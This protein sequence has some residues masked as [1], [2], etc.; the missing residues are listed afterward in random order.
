MNLM[1]IVTVILQI[2]TTIVVGIVGYFMKDK[3]ASLK[4]AD[5]ANEC[6]ITKIEDSF[7]EFKEK[8]PLLYTTRE[9]QIRS[10]AALESRVDKLGASMDSNFEK[11][12]T[13]IENKLDNFSKGIDDKVTQIGEQLNKHLQRE[14]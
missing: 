9:D 2:I 14:G 11:I 6:R 13:K 5:K 1:Q 12:N 3:F 7:S 8:M 10:Q 4:E